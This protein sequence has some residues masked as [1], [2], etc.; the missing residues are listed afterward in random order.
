MVKGTGGSEVITFSNR[1]KCSLRGMLLV[2]GMN[3]LGKRE[4]ELISKREKDLQ[5]VIPAFALF[6]WLH[7]RC[8]LHAHLRHKQFPEYPDSSLGNVGS[9]TQGQAH[10]CATFLSR[11]I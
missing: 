5:L 10:Q 1:V 4:N 11:G 6:E 2:V 9:H 7:A 8:R 3:G